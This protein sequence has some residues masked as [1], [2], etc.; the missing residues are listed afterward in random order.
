MFDVYGPR[1][2]MALG[3]AIYVTSMLLMSAAGSYRDYLLAQGVLSGLGVGMLYVT[4]AFDVVCVPR[5]SDDLMQ[6]LDLYPSDPAAGSPFDTGDS[7]A[8]TPQFKRMA[9]FQ[10]DYVFQAPRR[11]FIQQLSSSQPAWAY[12]E[13]RH[14]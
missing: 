14:L 6:V 3:T 8:V 11:L 9:A 4:P 5:S 12:G 13:R 1:V 10:G 7:F 2:I